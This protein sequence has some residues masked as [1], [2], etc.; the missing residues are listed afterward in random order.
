M[1]QQAAEARRAAD[2]IAIAQDA[3]PAVIRE[4]LDG[5]YNESP[6]EETTFATNER[7]LRTCT[8]LLLDGADLC[9]DGAPT[10][11]HWAA[12][13]PELN[14]VSLF[15][16]LVTADAI[17]ALFKG[18][19]HLEILN[20]EHAK[21]SSGAQQILPAADGYASGMR[22]KEIILND[23][24]GVTAGRIAALL[25]NCPHL[26]VLRLKGTGCVPADH[27]DAAGLPAALKKG[28]SKGVNP[29]NVTSMEFAGVNFGNA[30]PSKKDWS[31]FRDGLKE[32]DLSRAIGV[33][34]AGIV[35]L[36][37][38]CA[39]LTAIGAE[40]T[41]VHCLPPDTSEK[42]PRVEF[43]TGVVFL[44]RRKYKSTAAKL[45]PVLQAGLK[46]RL[47]MFSDDTRKGPA[48]CTFL[49]LE[50]ADLS[51]GVPTET[52]WATFGPGLEEVNLQYAKGV[53]ADAVV[54]LLAACPN[55]HH[56]HLMGTGLHGVLHLL[57]A[58]ITDKCPQLEV[59]TLTRKLREALEH[60]ETQFSD[61]ANKG[62]ATCTALCLVEV[63]L[64]GDKNMPSEGDWGEFGSTLK[65]IDLERARGMTAE[66]VA[67]LVRACPNL[68]AIN[69]QD[70]RLVEAPVALG[71]LRHLDI[72]LLDGNP[73]LHSDPKWEGLNNMNFIAELQRLKNDPLL[74]LSVRPEPNP[75]IREN[76]LHAWERE[77][78]PLFDALL[79]MVRDWAFK[80]PID[81]TKWAYLEDYVFPLTE[82]WQDKKRFKMLKAVAEE[83][84]LELDEQSRTIVASI[85]NDFAGDGNWICTK[86]PSIE[87]DIAKGSLEGKGKS[88]W[89]HNGVL[90]GQRMLPDEAKN[91][92]DRE[93]LP[94]AVRCLADVS[95]DAFRSAVHAALPEG[96]Q[97]DDGS[98]EPPKGV[99]SVRCIKKKCVKS[100]KRMT[101]KVIEA[102]VEAKKQRAAKG[103]SKETWPFTATIGDALRASVTAPDAAGIRRAWECIRQSNKWTVIRLKNKFAK[104][105]G[106][107]ARNEEQVDDNGNV[108]YSSKL[109]ASFHR[110]VRRLQGIRRFS[111]SRATSFRY[112]NQLAHGK[113]TEFPNLHINVLFQAD[114]CAPIV[115]EPVK[116]LQNTFVD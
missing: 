65:K 105:T 116:I 29:A 56:L 7:N 73:F 70:C 47:S 57:P 101:A 9:R 114:G 96:T 11:A 90:A 18:C 10:V 93:V 89:L 71:D 103:A 54:A 16:A 66:G 44:E 104:A 78:G 52:D 41:G 94:T 23:A 67:A 107:L 92:F 2:A 61:N 72:L 4:G 21:R 99:L 33:T 111:L 80:P 98:E 40:E 63:D 34:A 45:G 38:Q 31:V 42:Y 39:N 51:G 115:A 37:A 81:N 3:L 17:A 27:P 50:K 5:E 6:D 87:G 60:K 113:K 14:E 19:S 32:V 83:N 24:E 15:N 25:D 109:K 82:V 55:V 62:P 20:L 28:F 30:M 36:L 86:L 64:R 26:E 106:S 76:F 74:C 58:S 46:H 8:K 112:S 48:T 22:L 59:I 43:G 97:L 12:F 100:V 95:F 13:G 84:K 77:E 1:R 68:E 49:H 102:Q 69:L 35:A 79:A 88:C 91:Q 75:F 85:A 108:V 110:A 53:T